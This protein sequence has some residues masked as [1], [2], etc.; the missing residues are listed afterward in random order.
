MAMTH[1]PSLQP[2]V[3]QNG[4][5]PT[6][7]GQSSAAMQP[8]PCPPSPPPP[9]LVELLV[10]SPPAP[11]DVVPEVAVPDVPS[12]SQPQRTRRTAAAPNH[13]RMDPSVERR[14]KRAQAL[15]TAEPSR[16]LL[17]LHLLLGEQD[18]DGR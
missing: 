7:S 14:V 17:S 8:P 6:G 16:L 10:A 4:S 5:I 12:S 18:A 15:R 9:E 11:V 2:G 13:H 1:S 3:A